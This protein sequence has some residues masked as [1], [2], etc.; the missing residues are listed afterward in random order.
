V[1]QR[2]QVFVRIR[3]AAIAAA[4]SPSPTTSAAPS[5]TRC[6]LETSM[7]PSIQAT[8]VVRL[9]P[10]AHPLVRS[11]GLVLASGLLGDE[12]RTEQAQI[13]FVGRLVDRAG[14]PARPSLTRAC[15]AG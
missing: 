15:S 9:V 7:L 10:L 3:A 11:L 6:C 8:P 2:T 13:R 12:R 14:E 4:A 5:L 1:R